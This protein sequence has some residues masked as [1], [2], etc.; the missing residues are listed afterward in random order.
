VA[1]GS[2][3]IADEELIYRRVPLQWL[4]P[5]DG[6]D[7]QAFAPHKVRDVT[8]I[9]FSRAKY[10]AI[11]DAAKGQ[12]GKSYYVAILRAGDIRAAGTDIVARPLK[13]D[14]GHAEL[15][16]LHA[17]EY[18]S[19]RTLELQRVLVRLTRRIEGPFASG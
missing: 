19:D 17:A 7:D 12:A 11:E 3:P 8:G 18:K 13:D 9:S 5:A 2:E 4:S 10:K 14:P 6:L 16:V 1:D 15:P